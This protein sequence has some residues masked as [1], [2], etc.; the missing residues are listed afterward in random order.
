MRTNEKCAVLLHPD[1]IKYADTVTLE[2]GQ[3]GDSVDSSAL[4]SAAEG[5]EGA[6]PGSNIINRGFADY[7]VI[8][9]LGATP[10]TTA[11]T[12]ANLEASVPLR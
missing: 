5:G 7:G 2:P 3:G 9:N 6:S 4:E 1:A 10:Q 11:T 12:D 8:F